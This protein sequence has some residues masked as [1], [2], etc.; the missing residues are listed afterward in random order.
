MGQAPEPTVDDY[1]LGARKLASFGSMLVSLAG[2]EPFLRTDLPNIVAAI[3]E[4]HLPFVTTNGWLVDE[5]IARDVMAAG[6]WGVS[7]SIDYSDPAMHDSARGMDGAWEQAWKAVE[8]FS[9]ARKYDYQRVNVMGVLLDD[10]IDHLEDLMKMAADRNAYFM[11]QPYGHRKINSKKYEHRD[12]AVSPRLLDMWKRNQNFLSN[13]VYLGKFDEFLNG[14][15]SNC[16]AGR[17][18]FNIDST[19]D[20][21]ICV[22]NRPTPIANLISDTQ[23]KIRDALRTAS[24]NNDCTCCWYNCR[25]EVE[26]LYKPRSLMMSLPTFFFNRGSADG[27]KMGRW[28]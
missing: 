7:I 27:E 12:G 18:F 11:V 19:G 6:L 22:E 24:K 5:K 20:I 25:G 1:A 23:Y 17:A 28:K 10:N 9:A 15:V 3:A 4:Y 14:G 13:P 26:S 8:I 2:G 16:R 21:A